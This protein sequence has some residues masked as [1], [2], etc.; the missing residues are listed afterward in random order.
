VAPVLAGAQS[1]TLSTASLQSTAYQVDLSAENAANQ[2]ASSGLGYDTLQEFAISSADES[3][4]LIGLPL[5][6][7]LFCTELG[8]DSPGTGNQPSPTTYTVVPISSADMGRASTSVDAYAGVPS[9]GIGNGMATKLEKLYG[10]VFPT[11][12][13]SSPLN[14]GFG[15]LVMTGGSGA[16]YNS[17]VFQLA[18]WQVAETNSFANIQLAGPGFFLSSSNTPGL[19]ADADTLLQAVG[20]ASNVTLLNLDSLHSA[21]GQ[22][23]IL[24]DPTGSLIPIPEPSAW[25][26][27]L[28]AACLA[29]ALVR[30]GVA[31]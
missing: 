12:S 31:A 19:V 8:Q 28:G 27:V 26:L 7:N 10:F 29:L 30:R 20:S 5:Q 14:I 9:T 2:T 1:V 18:V 17:A 21:T 23:L 3:P 4:V 6:L 13:S 11:Y 16:A 22:D 24:P 15:S 25:A